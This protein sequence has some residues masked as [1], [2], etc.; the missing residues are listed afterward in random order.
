VYCCF[1]Q[2]IIPIGLKTDASRRTPSTGVPDYTSKSDK[3]LNT[4]IIF[5]PTVG[6]NGTQLTCPALQQDLPNGK[7]ETVTFLLV[8]Q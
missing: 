1:L 4:T 6:L 3:K 8:C 5:D 2:T 7:A